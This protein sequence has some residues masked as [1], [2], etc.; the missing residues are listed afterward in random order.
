MIAQSFR[1]VPRV[2]LY[3]YIPNVKILSKAQFHKLLNDVRYV[4][5]FEG[6]ELLTRVRKSHDY[7]RKEYERA[8]LFQRIPL[9]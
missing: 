2:Y 5:K 1:I 8:I 6:R 7:R 4:L 3:N 9:S